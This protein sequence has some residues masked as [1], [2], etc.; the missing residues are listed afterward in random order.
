[1]NHRTRNNLVITV[2]A[3]VVA[4]VLVIFVPAVDSIKREDARAKAEYSAEVE[5]YERNLEGREWVAV[6]IPAGRGWYH[7]CDVSRLS[8]EITWSNRETVRDLIAA[9]PLNA[10][11]NV[12]N[13][14]AGSTIWVP[15][16]DPKNSL[17]ALSSFD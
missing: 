15:K 12:S 6:R 2:F 8:K 14:S 10:R 9:N 7:A 13:P 4:T 11:V 16:G 1:M 5:A 17:L 3:L